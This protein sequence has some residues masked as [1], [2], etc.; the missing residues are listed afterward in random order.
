MRNLLNLPP[1]LLVVLASATLAATAAAQT[2]LPVF[3]NLWN[4]GSGTNAPALPNDLPNAGNSV[5][6]IAVNP[7]T[8]NV[9][10]ASTTG[11][12]NNGNNHVTVLDTANGGAYLAQL[13]ASGVSGGAV[14]LAPV[15]A[16]EDG[17]VYA[18]AVAAPGV[19]PEFKLYRWPSDADVTTPASLILQINPAATRYGDFMD[20][21]G[22]GMDT[23]I[24]VGGNGNGFL[25]VKPAEPTLTTWTNVAL[26]FPGGVAMSGRGIAFEGTS[27]AF[28]GK[29]NGSA[30]V[31]R[32]AYDTAIPT[33]YVT[34]TFALD[35]SQAV[36][37]DY[38]EINGLKL[39]SAVVCSTA[40][41][42]N[43]AAHRARVY[44]LTGPSNVVS[45]LDRNLP[46]PNQGNGNSLAMSDIQQ[47]HFAFSEPNN[48]ISFYAVSFVTNL[49]PSVS[50]GAQ[51]VGA[52]VVQ[53]NNYAFSV[54]AS[55]TAPL[56]YQWYFN[57]TNVL[58]G[59][60]SSTLP[61]TAVQPAQSGGYQVVITNAFGAVT[62][63]V[64]NLT[65]LPANLSAVA[66]PLWTL[67][68][69]SRNYLT[70]DNTQRGLAYDAVTGRLVLVSRAPTNGVHLL[71]AATGADLG[72]LDMSQANI[73]GPGTYVINMAGVSADG[74]VYA[75]N[76]LNS[77]TTDSFVI[78]RWDSAN[79]PPA[80]Y[81]YPV[82]SGNPGVGRLGD[83]FAVRGAGANTEMLAAVRTGTNVVLFT[84]NDGVGY[85]YQPNVLAITNLPE[86][87]QANGFAGLGLAFGPTNTFW[88]KSTGFM[89][90]LVRYDAASLTGEV[91]A[92]YDAA[93]ATMGPIGADN[94]NSLVAGIGVGEL[95][96]N[97]EFWDVAGPDDATLIDREFFPASNP[98]GNGTGAV[99]FDTAAGRIFALDSNSG[100]LAAKYAP[101][102]RFTQI[103]SSLVLSWAGPAKLQH[104][105]I[106]T[107]P[108]TEV[109][110]A[111]SPYVVPAG[112]THFYRLAN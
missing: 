83:T 97:L 76:L 9:L 51:P 10:Y 21:R 96:Q 55:G 95:P 3:T 20:V 68:P 112:G 11:G 62:S 71:Q 69:G 100:L 4:L 77:S 65:V 33:N 91:I 41:V 99:A 44:Q 70:T 19:N 50:A 104:A 106:V 6:G 2:P 39:L 1:R 7:L 90:R 101:L 61:L 29:A 31:Y 25:L 79:P 54:T 98:N 12:T 36:G 58:A 81:Q 42:T 84:A 67:A 108:Y 34:A 48:G 107:G 93:D 92:A 32:V 63:L 75:C 74:V 80:A 5:R 60:T 37:I 28:F 49:P 27:R 38:A 14:N 40:A 13:N 73:P 109:S 24:L 53:G 88:A 18:C 78:Y 23:E 8:T 46:F 59:A 103:G 15:R 47:G 89:L 30:T 111:A 26:T 72:D 82:Y 64:A 17:A 94:A 43:G 22:A 56:A 86:A 57:A 66:S 110:G 105:S 45:V 85:N 102:L 35:Q 52:S 87:A 16:A